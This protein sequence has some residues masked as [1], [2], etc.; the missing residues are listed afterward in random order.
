MEK[1]KK[2]M[3]FSHFDLDGIV[4]YLV[5]RWA[6]PR[7]NIECELATAQNF[8][9]R[10][11]TWMTNNDIDDYD[12]IF[13][14]DLGI[15]DHIDLVDRNNVFIID[16]HEGHDNNTYKHA[17]SVI[18]NYSSA[19]LL[20]YKTLKKLYN[21]KLTKPQLHLILL[22]D[23]FDSYSFKLD[24]SR[25]LDIVFWGLSDKF[26]AFIKSFGGGFHGFN[27][28]HQNIIKLHMDELKD[29]TNKM[30]VFSGNIDIQGKTRRV[31]GTFA[32]KYINEVADILISDYDAEVVLIINIKN[33]HVSYRRRPN[34][35]VNLK[36]LAVTLGNG[37]TSGGHEYASGSEITERV[38]AFTKLLN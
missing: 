27:M 34:S 15:Y 6:F 33:N 4:S 36:E 20:A 13:I 25:E 16:H 17:K 1:V 23:D 12:T 30:E 14:T 19:A 37:E 38:Q 5:V 10:F 9:D 2:I 31:C 18:V 24:H 35:D 11:T 7:A 22:A 21:I 26:N 3:V 32:S 29:I 28:Q 8:R